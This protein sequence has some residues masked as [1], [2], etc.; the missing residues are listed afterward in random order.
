M[1]EEFGYDFLYFF[2]QLQTKKFEMMSVVKLKL[3][4]MKLSNKNEQKTND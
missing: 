1:D 3:L 4:N 2:F